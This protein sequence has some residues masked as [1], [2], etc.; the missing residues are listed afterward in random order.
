MR[1]S[2]ILKSGAT[3][4]LRRFK[5]RFPFRPQGQSAPDE[6]KWEL[7]VSEIAAYHRGLTAES[8][9]ADQVDDRAWSDLEL[10]K[11]FT[12]L[13]RCVTPLGA[14]YLYALFRNYQTQPANL[15]ANVKAY[16]TFKSE[17]QV[18]SALRAALAKLN[19][20]ES[21]DLADFLLGPPPTVPTHYRF[22]YVASALAIACPFGLFFSAWFL[23]AFMAFLGVN[24]FLYYLYSPGLVRHSPALLTLGVLL[25]CLP[26]IAQALQDTNLPEL[27]EIQTSASV[28]RKIQKRISLAF[29]RGQGGDD[30]TRILIE[31]LN[32]LCLF[33]V[34]ALCRA[35]QAVNQKRQAL[36]NLFR[37]VARL[38][39]LQGI[40]NALAEYPSV[41]V[42]EMKAGRPFS[43]LEVQH[44][45]VRNPVCNSVEGSGNS[46]L[47]TGTNM[48]GKTTFIKTL[49]VNLIFAQTLGVCLAKKAVLPPA[50][51]RTLIE[52]EDIIT[53]GQSYF[54]FEA[55]ELLRMLN[56]AAQSGREHW[57]VLDE[58]FR[59]T[60]TLERVSAGSA[61]LNYLAS[62]GFVIA[63]THDHEL[64]TLLHNDFDLYHFSEV[65]NGN[66][67]RFDYR[68]RKGPCTTRNAIKLMAI[69]GFPKSVTDLAEKLAA[70]GHSPVELPRIRHL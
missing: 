28:A 46:L 64:C 25:A 4:V 53:S 51:V 34:T 42:P 22:F 61:V 23:P 11:I 55:S 15:A 57:F 41:C 45:L 33:E 6:Q 32:M 56:D 27:G 68:L 36:L 5:S 35:I 62:F 50:R 69:V 37:V 21:A 10:E 12:R 54:Y 17:P 19:R 59:G 24:I 8:P 58:I 49:A 2:Q 67:A 16:G 60:N 44:P 3:A 14:Q 40:S 66:E 26:K 30:L 52:R 1:L 63:S 70:G 48:A 29:L 20:R 38:D 13:N 39:A 9:N 43:F 47:L 18:L 65:I 31:Y 7:T